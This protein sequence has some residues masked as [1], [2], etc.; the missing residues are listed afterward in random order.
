MKPKPMDLPHPE[1]PRF[2]ICST[3]RSGTT[4][5]SEVFSALGAP[6]VQKEHFSVDWLKESLLAGSVSLPQSWIHAGGGVSGWPTFAAL[7]SVPDDVPVF[8]Q[9]RDPRDVVWSLQHAA[10]VDRAMNGDVTYQW[11]HFSGLV[12]YSMTPDD[13]IT[14]EFWYTYWLRFNQKIERT[15]AERGFPSIRYK[16]EVLQ[17]PENPLAV[18]MMQGLLDTV[19]VE[20]EPNK[21]RTTLEYFGQEWSS[22]ERRAFSHGVSWDGVPQQVKDMAARYG[23][24]VDA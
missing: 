12:P 24:E 21:I 4:K 23:Y 2:L 13:F 11:A 16:I 8:H 6:C 5:M 22:G 20:E 1:N 7:D 10:S 18:P 14:E 15:I 17:D 3:G 9:T 19:G